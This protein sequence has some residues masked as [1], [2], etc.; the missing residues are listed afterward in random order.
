MTHKTISIKKEDY[1]AAAELSGRMQIILKRPV[2]L[3]EAVGHAC[4]YILSETKRIER[5]LKEEVK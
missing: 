3:G 1:I 2:S 5:L 4:R